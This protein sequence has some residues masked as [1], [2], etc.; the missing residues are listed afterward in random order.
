MAPFCTN[1]LIFIANAILI[2]RPFRILILILILLI[3]FAGVQA[4]P[5]IGSTGFA[6]ILTHPFTYPLSFAP[7]PS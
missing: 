7:F 3:L 5:M 1:S 6:F 4:K 2:L